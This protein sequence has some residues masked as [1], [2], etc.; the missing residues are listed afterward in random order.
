MLWDDFIPFQNNSQNPSPFAICF[1]DKPP[2]LYLARSHMW[3]SP[4]AWKTE[5]YGSIRSLH[6][7]ML[8]AAKPNQK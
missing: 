2:I 8:N 6:H 3:H 5:L 4:K 7:N 1:G